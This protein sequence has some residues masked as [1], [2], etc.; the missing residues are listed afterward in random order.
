ME[1]LNSGVICPHYHDG[2]VSVGLR[3]ITFALKVLHLRWSGNIPKE[4]MA[5]HQNKIEAGRRCIQVA[6]H[7]M[8]VK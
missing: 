7:D 2:C 3:Y 6:I 5:M 1:E 8:I 4:L